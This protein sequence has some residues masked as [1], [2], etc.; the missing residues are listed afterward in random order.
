MTGSGTA[1][2]RAAAL[3]EGMRA[4]WESNAQAR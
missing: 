1:W 2:S 4:R 3:R